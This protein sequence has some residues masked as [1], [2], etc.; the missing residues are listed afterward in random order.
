MWQLQDGSGHFVHEK[1]GFNT[2]LT[3]HGPS[4]SYTEINARGDSVSATKGNKYSYNMGHEC[5][6]CEGNQSGKTDGHGVQSGGMGTMTASGGD[7]HSSTG[8]DSVSATMGSTNQA[9]MG[10]KY[11]GVKGNTRKNTGGSESKVVGGMGQGNYAQS[12]KG[13]STRTSQGQS[14]VESKG[15]NLNLIG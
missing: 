9:S 11:T 4:G 5:K 15:G 7:S 6:T 8:G 10:D 12:V 14:T 3:Q 13:T 1:N 2:Q